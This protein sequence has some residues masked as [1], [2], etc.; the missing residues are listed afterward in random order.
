MSPEETIQTRLIILLKKTQ[1]KYF[2]ILT[3]CCKNQSRI[4]KRCAFSFLSV[5]ACTSL[6]P[7]P[8]L[9]LHNELLVTEEKSESEFSISHQTWCGVSPS[10][11][12]FFFSFFFNSTAVP[13]P[14]SEDCS[15]SRDW[16][17]SG[18]CECMNVN[19]ANYSRW[20]LHLGSLFGALS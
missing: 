3:A 10:L 7:A 13:V 11:F 9:F 4:G 2:A 1:Q 6:S 8:R 16:L 17:N 12:F 14:V 18:R 5:L 19:V 15:A 20:T